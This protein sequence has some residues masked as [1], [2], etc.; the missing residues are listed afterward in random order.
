MGLSI[1]SNMDELLN[2]YIARHEE[3]YK[4]NRHKGEKFSLENVT[5]WKFL[6]IL[7]IIHRCRR[8]FGVYV[9]I[10]WQFALCTFEGVVLKRIAILNCCILRKKEGRRGKS[11]SIVPH[12]NYM[13]TKHFTAHMSRQCI[14]TLMGGKNPKLIQQRFIYLYS[15]SQMEI[16]EPENVS[17]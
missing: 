9:T 3:R 15:N 6:L 10:D 16:T 2:S 4:G 12:C 11:I 5:A 14:Y 17:Y 7:K 8:V 1:L 13:N